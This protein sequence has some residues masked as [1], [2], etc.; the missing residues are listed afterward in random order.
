MYLSIIYLY[1]IFFTHSSVSV[2]VLTRYPKT[3]LGDEMQ[4]IE[5]EL[6]HIQLKVITGLELCRRQVCLT[7][8]QPGK[9]TPL[10]GRELRVCVHACVRVRVCVHV[11]VLGVLW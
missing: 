10:R 8:P 7:C 11:C 5:S 9:E 1:H 3:C 6:D 2:K 4:S